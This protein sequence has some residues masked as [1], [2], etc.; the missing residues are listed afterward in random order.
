M[1]V[2]TAAGQ[3]LLKTP[4]L[5]TA[6]AKASGPAFTVSQQHLA[7]QDHVAHQASW[8][9]LDERLHARDAGKHIDAVDSKHPQHLKGEVRVPDRLIDEG[10]SP[11]HGNG[12]ARH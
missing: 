7:L 12:R 2:R 8:V 5:R 1:S 9:G 4:R 11:D 3:R 6:D 10:G